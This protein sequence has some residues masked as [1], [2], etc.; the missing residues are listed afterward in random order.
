MNDQPNEN[1]STNAEEFKQWLALGAS[2]A[3][4]Q[5]LNLPLGDVPVTLVPKGYEVKTHEG[6]LEKFSNAPKRL[7]QGV[8]LRDPDSFIAYMKRHATS[9]TAIFCDTD[10]HRFVG[11]LDYHDGT[12]PHHCEHTAV[13]SLDKTPELQTW[14]DNDRTAMSQ[15]EFAHFIENNASEIISTQLEGTDTA[16]PSGTEMLEI[17]LT[18]SQTENVAFRSAQRLSDGQTQL[19]FEQQIEGRA[20]EQGELTIPEMIQ[21]GLPLFKSADP[22]EGYAI[23]ARFRYRRQS[24][25]LKMWYELVR[26]ERII[27]DAVNTIH[28]KLVNGLQDKAF[29]FYHGITN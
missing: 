21:I 26:P 19:R 3:E 20:G 7:Q 27:E 10:N 13:L 24:S 28:E 22:A 14:L 5:A 11:I 16:T 9:S 4:P 23:K 6:L 2:V 8:K 29:A 1:R 18:L 25:Q 15:I 17:A 12:D